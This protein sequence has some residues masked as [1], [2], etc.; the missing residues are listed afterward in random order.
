VYLSEHDLLRINV[1]TANTYYFV[2]N[3]HIPSLSDN[4]PYFGSVT[5]SVQFTYYCFIH[6]WFLYPSTFCPHINIT[7]QIL[8][9]EV[10]R[11]GKRCH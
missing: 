8:A 2:L 10:G 3:R 4:L 1:I 9:R 11:G 7:S 5:D 6:R